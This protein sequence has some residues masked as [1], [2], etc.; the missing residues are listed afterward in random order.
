MEELKHRQQQEMEGKLQSHS[1][2]PLM[3]Q[4]LA[5]YWHQLHVCIFENSQLEGLYVEE[6]LYNIGKGQK[7]FPHCIR[8]IYF[9]LFRKKKKKKRPR[10]LDCH[11]SLTEGSREREEKSVSDATIKE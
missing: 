2:L 9:S 1:H 11:R 4:A 3:A 7:G 10:R 5:P 6:S 8:K